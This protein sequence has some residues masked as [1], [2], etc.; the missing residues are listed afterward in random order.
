MG[1]T[2]E[3]RILMM[4]RG[5][6]NIL[7]LLG[8]TTRNPKLML[9]KRI[10][11]SS[12]FKKRW[13]GLPHCLHMVI[14]LRISTTY[15]IVY[16]NRWS[17]SINNWNIP[18]ANPWCLGCAY[19]TRPFHLPYTAAP[20]SIDGLGVNWPWWARERRVLPFRSPGEMGESR[21]RGVFGGEKSGGIGM[22]LVKEKCQGW[23]ILVVCE[24]E[25]FAL[26]V[27]SIFV[28]QFRNGKYE[29]L[30]F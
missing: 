29:L 16:S 11:W 19:G 30:N 4:P 9:H 5:L 26:W 10:I 21:T 17:N 28:M 23:I 15:S 24:L 6:W 27:R 2:R 8:F 1:K 20:D 25:L 7:V 18:A 14:H 13:K 12:M 3:K 22:S